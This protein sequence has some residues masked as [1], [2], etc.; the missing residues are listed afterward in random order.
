MA[1]G[2][3]LSSVVCLVSLHFP[4]LFSKCPWPQMALLGQIMIAVHMNKQHEQPLFEM[5]VKLGMD[6]S[7][8]EH[9]K[10]VQGGIHPLPG[11]RR[12]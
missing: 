7:C 8:G 6:T 9:R 11:G 5:L 12:S 10:L 1:G 3:A 2:R 4:M